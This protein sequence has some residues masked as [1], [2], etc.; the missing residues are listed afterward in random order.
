MSM[1]TN[2]IELTY[3]SNPSAWSMATFQFRSFTNATTEKATWEL[4]LTKIDAEADALFYIYH[5]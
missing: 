2:D 1:P 3:K 5:I 4:R